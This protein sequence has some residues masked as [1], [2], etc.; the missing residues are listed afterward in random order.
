[1]SHNLIKGGG[2]Q[3]W[4]EISH[5]VWSEGERGGSMF[6]N[7]KLISENCDISNWNTLFRLWGQSGRQAQTSG[8]LRQKVERSWN[9]M[10]WYRGWDSYMYPR[11]LIYQDWRILRLLF[12][13]FCRCC[14]C[15]HPCSRDN[16]IYIFF[17]GLSFHTNSWPDDFN[18]AGKRLAVIGKTR[19]R[20]NLSDR[21]V[22]AHMQWKCLSFIAENY[23]YKLS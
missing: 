6:H 11:C 20:Y 8:Q 2:G 9:A 4:V 15:P 17:Q 5:Q 13:D 16:P 23:T 12:C 21:N 1:M 10:C 18:C 22:T 7:K 14:C 3:V 19:R